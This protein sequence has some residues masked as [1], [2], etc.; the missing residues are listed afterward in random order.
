MRRAARHRPRA[1]VAA[2]VALLTLPALRA[3]PASALLSSS[4]GASQQLSSGTLAA[5]RNLSAA[6]GTCLRGNSVTV[7]LTWEEPLDPVTDGYDIFRST[8]G[9]AYQLIATVSGRAT[10]GYT[11]ATTTFST[12]YGYV[13]RST[14]NLWTGPDSNPASITTPVKGCM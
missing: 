9:G 11:D 13:V 10:T 7:Q 1:W 6:V 5:P 4:T 3:V 12:T 8:G 2:M 14:R